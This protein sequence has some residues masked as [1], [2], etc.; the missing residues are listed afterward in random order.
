MSPG[1]PPEPG[2]LERARTRW[3]DIKGI[4][5]LLANPRFLLPGGAWN[6]ARL[7]QGLAAR[8][9]NHVGLAFQDERY[10]WLEVDE[11]ANRYADFFVRH[12]VGRGDVVAL[13][14]DNRPD[15]LFVLAGLSR[16]RAVGALINSNL[17]GRPLVHA[18]NVGRPKMVVIGSEHLV[19]A[20][21]ALPDL[22]GV[23][24]EHGVVVQRDPESTVDTGSWRVIDD[25]VAAC[26]RHPLP[27]L[28]PPESGEPMCYIY[29]SGTTGLPKAAIITN[30]RWLLAG[31]LFGRVM[32]EATPRDVI[33]MTLPLYH[34]NGMFGGW[35]ASLVTG[36]TLALRRKFSASNFWKDVAR[37]DATVFIY[38]GE[39]CRYLLNHP[40]VPEERDHRLRLGIGNGL[41][42]D[43]WERFQTRFGIP[44]IRE[45]YGATEGNAVLV[46][47][48][49]R[50][51]MVGRLRPGQWI[52]RCD[53]ESG[54]IERNERGLCTPVAVGERG[55]LLG[56]ITG[57]TKFDGY[58][59]AEATRKKVVSDVLQKGDRY[60]N[61]GDV[62]CLHPDRWVSFADR[63]GDTFRWKG[64]N[65]STNEVAEVLNGAPG[66]HESNVYGVEVPGT[67]GRAGMASLRVAGDFDL[68]EF[69]RYVAENLPGYQRPHFIR[70][71]ND[72]RVTGTFKHQ[73]VDYRREG[74][75]PNRVRDPLYFL[76]GEHYVPITEDLYRRIESGEVAPR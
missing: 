8:L 16:L 74:Y 55:L 62:M 72:M 3:V 22:E 61:S 34:S 5:R 4:A 75:D 42:P 53:P 69:A 44:L 31:A 2:L 59:D 65:V 12:G 20:E 29:T 27:T 38:I 7:L 48:E 57:V 41:R 15:F 43:I 50:P 67:E 33:Y 30:Q 39:L 51:G 47:L 14:M 60:F 52:V 63:V 23:S 1:A 10:T 28:T 26:S 11:R 36:A 25:E 17:S 6:S 56:K 18:I 58:V 70:L 21:E 68:A 73:K 45:F 66:V 49:G 19:A 40:S 54:E 64:E 24:K 9:P 46:N 76:D 37:F 35:G 71:Q 13:F 32:A